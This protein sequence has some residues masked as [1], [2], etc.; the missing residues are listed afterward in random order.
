MLTVSTNNLIIFG[1]MVSF[2]IESYRF[3]D[4]QRYLKY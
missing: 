1:L 2:T 3:F 4:L